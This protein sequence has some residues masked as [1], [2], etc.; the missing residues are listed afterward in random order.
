MRKKLTRSILS[1][2][3]ATTLLCLTCPTP[4]RSQIPPSGGQA[5]D[6]NSDQFDKA[7][8]YREARRYAESAEE[9]RKVAELNVGT[10]L[11]ASAR[12]WRASTLQQSIN[13]PP[14]PAPPK[15]AAEKAELARMERAEWNTIIQKFPNTKYWLAA[16][17]ELGGDIAHTQ[18]VMV[19]LGMPAFQDVRSGKVRRVRE[20]SVPIQYRETIAGIYSGLSNP[21]RPLAERLRVLLFLRLSFPTSSSSGDFGPQIRDLFFQYGTATETEFK[22]V[23]T[24]SKPKRG[25]LVSRKMGT[26]KFQT[27][28]GNVNARQIDLQASRIE[29]DGRDIKSSCD[30]D[31]KID[32]KGKVFEKLKIVYH[33]PRPLTPGAHRYRIVAT[34]LGGLR[35]TEVNLDFRVKQ[36]GDRNEGCDD[37]K[38]DDRWDDGD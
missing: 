22:P 2:T 14:P 13:Y 16:V 35:T 36:S 31:A 1:L 37:R 12:Y 34:T 30:L 6:L 33:P 18:R 15:S 24:V 10:E 20:D 7:W 27:A 26:L 19:S 17:L 5:G 25:S 9:F 3:C 4:V 28:G 23:V 8:T 38:E 29:L 32:P 21:E 11:E